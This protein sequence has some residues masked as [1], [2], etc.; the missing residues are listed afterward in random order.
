VWSEVLMLTTPA[1]RPS[2]PKTKAV[3]DSALEIYW[4]RYVPGIA[5]HRTHHSARTRVYFVFLAVVCHLC[6]C[7]VCSRPYLRDEP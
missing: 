3:Q 5:S 4:S 6:H 1:W 7:Y 2:A